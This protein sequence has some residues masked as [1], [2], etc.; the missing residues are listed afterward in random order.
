MEGR[1][2]SNPA[3]NLTFHFDISGF[4]EQEKESWRHTWNSTS[5][6]NQRREKTCF[7]SDSCASYWKWCDK[8][9]SLRNRALP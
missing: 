5:L 9:G 1:V 4:A 2:G 7:K 8:D 6:M 3:P